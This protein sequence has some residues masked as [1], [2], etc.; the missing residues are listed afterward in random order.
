MSQRQKSGNEKLML[1]MG[2]RS[3]DPIPPDQHQWQSAPGEPPLHRIWSF[4]CAHTIHF[5]H[6]SPFAV[7]TDGHVL[8]LRNLATALGMGIENARMYWRLGCERGLWRNGTKAE[9]QERLYLCGKVRPAAVQ[10]GEETANG[11]IC[12]YLFPPYVLK[13][14]KDLPVEHREK[15]IS[16]RQLDIEV[17]NEVQAELLAAQRVILDDIDDTHFREWG[18]PEKKRQGHKPRQAVPDASDRQK[19]I[20]VILPEVEKYVHMVASVVQ[21]RKIELSKS[22][23]DAAQTGAT[24]LPQKPPEKKE[25]RASAPSSGSHSHQEGQQPRD[26][27]ERK[28]L[29]ALEQSK[30]SEAEKNVADLL[31]SEFRRMQQAYP[32]FG[33]AQQPFSPTSKSDQLLVF[34]VLHEVGVQNAMFFVETCA[35]NLRRTDHNALG[36]DL[37]RRRGSAGPRSFGL[38][39]EWARD[40]AAAL[41]ESARATREESR[42][43]RAYIINSCHDC[44]QDLHK[45]GER[46][47]SIGMDPRQEEMAAL[48]DLTAASVQL[49]ADPDEPAQGKEQIRKLLAAYGVPLTAAAG[50]AV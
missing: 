3:F 4:M 13:W 2:A 28:Q 50:G 21:T 31:F 41:K 33:F 6:D 25:T 23:V 14:L 45:N 20:R 42:R 27:Q 8:A 36:K 29:P 15:L 35:Q 48:K 26:E 39:L 30:L 37:G 5:G 9:G 11:E 32:H 40:F 47:R 44:I 34:R 1:A 43:T 24:L 46:Y 17:R 49:L 22:Q 16:L 7:S 12:T 10:Q 18:L 19:R 38:I